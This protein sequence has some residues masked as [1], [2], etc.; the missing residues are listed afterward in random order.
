MLVEGGKGVGGRGRGYGGGVG[1][2]VGGKGGCDGVCQGGPEG[3]SGEVLIF[4]YN[5]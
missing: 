2:K 5:Y 1:G 3:S 4:D